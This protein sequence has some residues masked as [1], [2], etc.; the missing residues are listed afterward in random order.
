MIKKRWARS[1]RWLRMMM[2]TVC[3]QWMWKKAPEWML[4]EWSLLRLSCDGRTRAP[5]AFI[6]FMRVASSRVRFAIGKFKFCW[7]KNRLEIFT[8]FFHMT[9]AEIWLAAFYPHSV[10][11]IVIVV[12]LFLYFLVCF[13]RIF[14]SLF[15]L[16]F[17]Y[18]H[19]GIEQYPFMH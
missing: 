8:F 2:P 9:T 15:S 10:N 11:F 5:L 4:S 12:L 13:L 17:F 6:C 3:A 1:Y 7:W 18:Q 14:L 19:Q 16:S